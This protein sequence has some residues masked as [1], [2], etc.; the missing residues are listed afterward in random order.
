MARTRTFRRASG[1]KRS[2]FWEGSVLDV[3]IVGGGSGG[4][5]IITE[6]QF[7]QVPNPTLIRVR[8][9]I[10]LRGTAIGAAEARGQ[11]T[12]GLIVVTQKAFTAGLASMPAPATD[13]SSDWL[14]WDTRTMVVQSATADEDT[15]LGINRL[16]PVDNKAMR[17]IEMNQLLAFI[18]QNVS[19]NS[20]I[21]TQV[22]GHLRVLIK[23]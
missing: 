6:A 11:I 17:K 1:P 2:M 21:T 10:N 8:G 19:L 12:M 22:S 15:A 4:V 7:E 14:W 3:S 23:R 18:V 16:I 9:V 20:S 5:E 13:I